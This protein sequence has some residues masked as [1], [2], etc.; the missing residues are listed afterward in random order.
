MFLADGEPIDLFEFADSPHTAGDVEM[1]NY[2]TSTHPGSI[3]RHTLTIQRITAEERL[4]LR[5]R[6]VTRYRDGIRTDTPIEPSDVRRLAQELFGIEIGDS[7]L[8]Y[9]SETLAP[10]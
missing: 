4:I 10:G 2:Y 6:V 1:A 9:E 5:P 3:F 8:L 7:A